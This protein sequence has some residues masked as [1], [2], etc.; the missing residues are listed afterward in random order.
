MKEKSVEMNSVIVI[1]NPEE[2]LINQDVPTERLQEKNEELFNGL[3]EEAKFII[4]P[5]V[6]VLAEVKEIIGTKLSSGE[7][8]C[9]METVEVY[10]LYL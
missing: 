6:L 1:K 10:I 9:D 5:L 3:T 7:Q 2:A 4:L 8:S